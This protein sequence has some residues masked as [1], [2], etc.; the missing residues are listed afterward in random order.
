MH[1]RTIFL[2]KVFD[3][4]CHL[5]K[6]C[7]NGNAGCSHFCTDQFW[8][9]LCS[10]PAGMTLSANGRDCEGTVLAFVPVSMLYV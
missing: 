6:S 5:G 1:L 3:F 9:A 8:G 7:L 4:S 2:C 10:C